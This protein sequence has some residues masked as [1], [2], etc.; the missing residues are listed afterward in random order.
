[1]RSDMHKVI[2]ERPRWTPGPDKYARRAHLPDELLPRFEGIKRMHTQRKGQRDLLGPLQRWLHSKI[3]HPWNEVYSEACSVIHFD[4]YVRVHV[5]T[6]LLQFVERN[7]FMHNGKVCVLDTGYRGRGIIQVTER[8]YGW[9]LFYVHPENGL[10][11]EIPQQP[12]PRRFDRNAERRAQMSRWV[13]ETSVLRQLNGCWFECG[14][15]PFP[16]RFAK[17]DSPWRFDVAEKKLICRSIA[18]DVY[19]KPVYCT[20]KR[21]LSRRELR[22]Y[23]LRN[24]SITRA[25][26]SIG[27][28]LLPIES[29]ALHSGSSH[30]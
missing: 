16:R 12:R 14:V 5:K 28:P 11:L 20:T 18:H 25:Q 13:N 26:P 19:A 4:N 15:A 6:H 29:C 10:L 21:Q 7:T 2:V 1:M 3:G 30:N 9:N 17:G 24:D 22:R 23:G 27:Y 8:R